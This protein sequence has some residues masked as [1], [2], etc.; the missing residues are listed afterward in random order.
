[1][2]AALGLFDHFQVFFQFFLAE[3]GGGIKPL[4]LLPRHDLLGSRSTDRHFVAE[5]DDDDVTHLRFGNG[6]CGAPVGPGA[7]LR[8]HF[9]RGNGLAGNVGPEAISRLVARTE[10]LPSITGVRNPIAARGGI[11]PETIAE[12]REAAPLNFRRQLRA[13]TGDDYAAFASQVGG[14][15]RAAGWLA[16]TGSWYEAA[17]AV[18]ALGGATNDALETAIEGRLERFRRIGHDLNVRP[19]RAVPV[20]LELCILVEP[21]VIRAH[22]ERAV[23]DLLGSRALPD[24]RLGF[25]HPDRLTFGGSIEVSAIVASVAALQGVR[26]AEVTKLQRLFVGPD[27][28]LVDG[29]LA[30]GPLEIARLDNDRGAPQNGRVALI[31]RGGR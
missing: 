22:V 17:V 20:D 8:A 25:F 14:V 10:R 13:V 4:K 7:R 24:G 9:R 11:D 19:A 29:R 6:D 30:I 1:V 27:G 5:T 2:V 23:L 3:P 15:A 28:E 31:M 16:W 26:T 21:D 12:A 18:D